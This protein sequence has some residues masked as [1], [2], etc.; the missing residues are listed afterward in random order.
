MPHMNDKVLPLGEQS[1]GNL[2]DLSA[3]YLP[4][5]IKWD[6]SSNGDKQL[7]QSMHDRDGEHC[8]CEVHH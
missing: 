5:R 3:Y 4:W 6:S 7:V 2:A 8:E 1:T